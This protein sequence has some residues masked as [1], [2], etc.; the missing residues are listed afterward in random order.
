MTES[1]VSDNLGHPGH[2]QPA[3]ESR[4]ARQAFPAKQQDHADPAQ[5]QVCP[6]DE[7]ECERH[8]KHPEKPQRRIPEPGERVGGERH[9]GKD[10]RIPERDLP[11][12]R[13][14]TMQEERVREVCDQGVRVIG[15]RRKGDAEGMACEGKEKEQSC[16]SDSQHQDPRTLESAVHGRSSP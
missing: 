7:V 14:G 6:E 4:Q 3:A 16:E 9:A 13:D 10:G 15:S 11:P 8:G 2:H 1:H 12:G 5:D